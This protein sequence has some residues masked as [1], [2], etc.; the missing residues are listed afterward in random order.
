[1]IS[2]MIYIATT[3][4]KKWQ[5]A[6]DDNSTKSSSIWADSALTGSVYS[7]THSKFI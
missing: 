2:K 3:L 6:L 1:M 4:N 5:F 7:R